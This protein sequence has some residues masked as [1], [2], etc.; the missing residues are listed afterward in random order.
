[1]T[2]QRDINPENDAKLD[3]MLD[4][5]FGNTNKNIV[6]GDVARMIKAR[7]RKHPGDHD[8]SVHSPTGRGGQSRHLS[9]LSPKA[10]EIW[11]RKSRGS[12][13][14]GQ[15]GVRRVLY[16]NPKTGGT[17][18]WPVEMVARE[19]TQ[20]QKQ[21]EDEI[22]NPPVERKVMKHGQHDQSSHS[23]TGRGAA[24]KKPLGYKDIPRLESRLGRHQQN[25]LDFARKY[26]GKWHGYSKD[27]LTGGAINALK[28]RGLVETNEFDQFRLGGAKKV[29]KT[30]KRGSTKPKGRRIMKRPVSKHGNHDQRTHGRAARRAFTS[31]TGALGAGRH[32]G[33]HIDEAL[34]E[35]DE[36]TIKDMINLSNPLLATIAGGR[37]GRSVI[38]TA[39]RTARGRK[40]PK[41]DERLLESFGFGKDRPQTPVNPQG[42]ILTPEGKKRESSPA[43]Q[44]TMGAL[45]RLAPGRKLW[46][47]RVRRA[48]N[49][50]KKTVKASL[51]ADLE[52]GISHSLETL[53]NAMRLIGEQR[54]DTEISPADEKKLQTLIDEIQSMI[55]Y[56][57]DVKE[58]GFFEKGEPKDPGSG[59]VSRPSFTTPAVAR[60]QHRGRIAI[61]AKG[62]GTSTARAAGY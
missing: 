59:F 19:E 58:Q 29:S 4:V 40:A 62:R 23:P 25:A 8:Q 49:E 13:S 28:E 37:F 47:A 54:P 61:N 42:F 57:K 12:R 46:T 52:K 11:N 33:Q 31:P 60:E 53:T 24:G 48:L 38:E 22:F 6:S 15:D 50:R 41:S 36:R 43:E 18:L 16:L 27:K 7:L 45:G 10:K 39:Q 44:A 51:N 30:V 3:K 21:F 2:V 1:M 5:K 35:L 14:I 32:A 20:T 55:G 9:R 26:P 56:L 17:E 34:G